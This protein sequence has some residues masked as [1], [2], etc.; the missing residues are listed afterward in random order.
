MT[1][2]L[3]AQRRRVS[4]PWMHGGWAAGRK[5]SCVAQGGHPA[6]ATQRR[7]GVHAGL[8]VG[9]EKK[10]FLSLDAWRLAGWLEEVLSSPGWAP[11]GCIAK[12][13]EVAGLGCP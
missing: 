3:L 4:C 6:D 12:P 1:G 5:K 7:S 11:C 9:P 10:A 2:S 13:V 8:A